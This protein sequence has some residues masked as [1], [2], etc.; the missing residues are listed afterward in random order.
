MPL[1]ERMSVI[2]ASFSALTLMIYMTGTASASK[3]ELIGLLE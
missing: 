3:V 2:S 1:V